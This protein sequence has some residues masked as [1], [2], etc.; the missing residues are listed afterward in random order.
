MII[1]QVSSQYGAPMGRSNGQ[2]ET[3]NTCYAMPVPLNDGYDFG[4]AYWGSGQQ[5]WAVIDQDGDSTF[6]RAADQSEAFDCAD[7]LT[8]YRQAELS[9]DYAR[10]YLAALIY[11]NAADRAND[12]DDDDDDNAAADWDDAAEMQQAVNLAS[13]IIAVDTLTSIR[14]IESIAEC[15]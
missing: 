13:S 6:H 3:E 1:T 4:G 15:Y 9:S 10:E 12:D 2:I 8:E 11:G 7:V 14:A 5:L